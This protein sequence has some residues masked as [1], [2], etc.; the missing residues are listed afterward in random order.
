MNVRAH[1]WQTRR[2]AE[3]LE[4]CECEEL[5]LRSGS[6]LFCGVMCFVSSSFILWFQN[7]LFMT[8]VHSFMLVEWMGGGSAVNFYS[9]SPT[10]YNLTLPRS[11]D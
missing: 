2:Q 11:V 5:R 6:P 3:S 8:H 1:H 10:N 9:K 7:I 4:E